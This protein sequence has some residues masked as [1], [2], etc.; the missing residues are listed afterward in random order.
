M[1][2]MLLAAVVCVAAVGAAAQGLDAKFDPRRDAAADVAR[3]VAQAG[4]QGKHVIVDVGGEWCA[5]CHILH[6]FIAR[7]VEVRAAIE[8]DYVWVKVNWSP[9][10]KNEQLL[11]AW[12]KVAGYPHLFVLDRS[13]RVIRSQPSVELES[14]TD[15]DVAKVLAFV[16]DSRPAR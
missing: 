9:A 13:G 11:S 3:A 10:N 8:A 16:R 12:P 4:E 2:K 1:R 15:Y 5:W 14:G 6:R 7:T